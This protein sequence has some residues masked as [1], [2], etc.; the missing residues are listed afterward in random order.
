[1][2]DK[3]PTTGKVSYKKY[4]CTKCGFVSE[5]QTNHWGHIYPCCE[6]CCNCE[7]ECLELV[8]EGYDVPERW[9]L[10]TIGEILVN[11]KKFDL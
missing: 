3:K 11:P 8:P 2:T 9:K 5:Q 4:R 6:K 1:M 7:H 10:V